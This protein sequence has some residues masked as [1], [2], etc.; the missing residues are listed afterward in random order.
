MADAP[1]TLD[2]TLAGAALFTKLARRRGFYFAE[3]GT[4]QCP[5]GAGAPGQY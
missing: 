5:P 3:C 1:P 4:V 2:R